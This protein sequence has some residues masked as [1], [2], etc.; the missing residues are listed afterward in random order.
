M[1]A[2]P[3][4]PI[5]SYT[6]SN[7]S[8]ILIYDIVGM[9]YDD[10]VKWRPVERNTCGRMRTSKVRYDGDRDYFVAGNLRIYLDECMR[11]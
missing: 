6:L 3:Q 8:G 10:Y 5:A 9:V 2:D 11:C 7:N 1:I 4:R